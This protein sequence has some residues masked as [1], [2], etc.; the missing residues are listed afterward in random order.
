MTPENLAMRIEDIA[1]NSVC[2]AD[3]LLLKEAAET[4]IQMAEALRLAHE[5]G[6]IEQ[7]H[8]DVFDRQKA[9]CAVAAALGNPIPSVQPTKRSQFKGQKDLFEGMA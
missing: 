9:T 4:V 7:G 2:E 3:S 5:H 1:L 6:C 8:C